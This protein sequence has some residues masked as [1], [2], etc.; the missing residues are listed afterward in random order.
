MAPTQWGIVAAGRI[1]NDFVVALSTLPREDHQ[2]VAVAGRN[3]ENAKKFGERHGISKVYATY[4]ELARDPDVEVAYVGS[5]HPDH[6]PTMKLLLESGKHVLCEKPLTMNCRDTEE[7]CKIAREKKLFLMEALWSRYLPAHLQMEEAIKSGLIGEPRY[8]HSTMGGPIRGFGRVYRK[9]LGGSVLLD[10]GCYCTSLALQVFGAETPL[11][12]SA[13]GELGT[14]GV[15]QHVAVVM[16]FNGGRLATFAVSG[17]VKMPCKAEIVGTKGAIT[18]HPPFHATTCIEMP[19]GKV[20]SPLPRGPSRLNFVNSTGMRYEAEEVRR[21]L[22][23]GLLES[24]RM[25]HK[26][27]ALVAGILDQILKQVGVQY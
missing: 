26:D 17:L 20:D 11:K 6:Y 15:D 12:V 2:V 16:E 1:S 10:I 27:S 22:R 3:F 4:E 5:L 18:L 24:P 14:E 9:E 8:V 21:C 13:H 7:I 19:S 23:E 25:T